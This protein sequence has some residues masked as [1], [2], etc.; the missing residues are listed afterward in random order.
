METMLANVNELETS[1][2][3]LRKKNEALIQDLAKYGVVWGDGSTPTTMASQTANATYASSPRDLRNTRQQQP[4]LGYN[5][6]YTRTGADIIG[7]GVDHNIYSQPLRNTLGQMVWP[8]SLPD[9]VSSN[10]I[11]LQ[12]AMSNSM[13]QR[14]QHLQGEAATAAML[15]E[16]TQQSAAMDIIQNRYPQLYNNALANGNQYID[17]GIRPYL[18]NNMYQQMYEE[19]SP[20]HRIGARQTTQMSPL[21]HPLLE[22]ANRHGQTNIPTS[23]NGSRDSARHFQY[24]PKRR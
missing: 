10:D 2:D 8:N 21:R 11:P 14:Q 12:Q 15:L 24:T 16:L 1:N 3:D 20:E 23:L 13:E 19:Q 18:Q 22:E 7:N 9:V 5:R 6:D 17:G 4:N